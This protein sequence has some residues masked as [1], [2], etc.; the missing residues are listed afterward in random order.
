M[1][2]I[3]SRKT[4]VQHTIE[5][6]SNAYNDHS[7]FPSRIPQSLCNTKKQMF[8]KE[9]SKHSVRHSKDSKSFKKKNE[10]R[11]PL[12]FRSIDRVTQSKAS[13]STIRDKSSN[14]KI[15]QKSCKMVK[16]SAA[17]AEKL[18]KNHI[19]HLCRR[20]PRK[21]RITAFAQEVAAKK[22]QSFF[23]NLIET[24]KERGRILLE[25]AVSA[26]RIKHAKRVVRKHLTNYILKIRAKKKM[27]KY[28]KKNLRKI[29]FIQQRFRLKKEKP[30]SKMNI[31]RFKQLFYAY[32]IG[33]R[34]RRI[35]SYIKTLPEIREAIDFIRLKI[36][37]ADEDPNV[38][39]YKKILEQYPSKVKLFNNK[40]T[41][42]FD[43]AV[44]IKK[45]KVDEEIKK[46]K[47]KPKTR[48]QNV[49]ISFINLLI[50]QL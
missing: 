10:K 2:R 39:F 29:I 47:V 13:T 28:Y 23:K 50:N 32:L 43:N 21:Y 12:N 33:W 3:S 8:G 14:A 6:S 42:L 38:L 27:V 26:F 48:K 45:P 49:G 41:D 15:C 40:Y 34:V 44:W 37:L 16:N 35:V 18:R 25:K 36:D 11:K 17:K 1:N 31:R 24:K 30:R 19:S 5:L 22:I 20:N 9:N 7:N 4:S 46:E